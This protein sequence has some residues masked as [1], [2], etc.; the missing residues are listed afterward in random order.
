MPAKQTF[1]QNQVPL[2]IFQG[3]RFERT[4]RQRMSDGTYRVFT[5][6]T[7]TCSFVPQLSGDSVEATVTVTTLDGESALAVVIP[8][9]DTQ[10]ME[11]KEYRWNIKIIPAGGDADDAEYLVG[12]IATVIEETTP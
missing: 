3:C 8:A 4:F 9:S 6:V 11:I 10:T 5:G 7:A 12:G 2:R 1:A